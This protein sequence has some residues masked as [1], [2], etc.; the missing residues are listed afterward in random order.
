MNILNGIAQLVLLA[1][2]NLIGKVRLATETGDEITD[3]TGD[4]VKEMPP[5]LE[6]THH[7]FGK[8]T[9]T[10]DG[11]Q[12]SAEAT[13]TD[14]DYKTVEEV[15][16][17]Q[18]AGYTLFEIELGL[19]LAIKSSGATESVPWKFQGSDNGSDYT[20]LIAEQT[21][22][23]DASA[24]ADVSCSGRFAPTGNFLGTGSTFKVKAMIKS[25][26]A[27]GETATGKAKNSSYIICRYRR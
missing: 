2:S 17:N 20:D 5:V 12:Y 16:I 21:R 9:L 27:G 15:T 22:A 6:V 7:P 25:G 19:T 26:A 18:P 10:T 14:D 13:T 24:Y 3:D 8:G 1:G 23:A 4:A 11:Q